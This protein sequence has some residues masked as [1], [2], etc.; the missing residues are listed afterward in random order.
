MEFFVVDLANPSGATESATAGRTEVHITSE[1][2][3][4][5]ASMDD[6]TVDEGAGT[7]K[8]TLRLNHPSSKQIR[9]TMSSDDV[10]GTATVSEDYVDFLGVF[11]I[12]AFIV[13]P[14]ELTKDFDIDIIDDGAAESDE[15]ITIKWTRDS[16]G[17][18]TPD[19]LNFTGTI[20]DNDGGTDP[21]LWSTTMTVGNPTGN[22]RGYNTNGD[23]HGSL[24]SLDVSE[25]AVGGVE[26]VVNSVTVD[27]NHFT[28]AY[29]AVSPALSN[30]GDYILEVAG[31]E[32]PLDSSGDYGSGA[33]FWGQTWLAA[34]APA[35]AADTFQ[36]TLPLDGRVQVCLRT[37]MERCPEITTTNTVATGKPTIT[38]TPQVGEV[39]TAT[40]GSIAD[41][42]DLPATFP[43]DYDFQWVSVDNSNNERLVGANSSTY[44]PDSS[45]V[46]KTIKVKVSFTDLRGL[47][48]GSADQRRRG[49]GGCGRTAGLCTGG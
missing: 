22:S 30:S 20:T 15:T 35:L 10:G 41:T 24:G 32:L 21:F 42:D 45:D 39:L 1:D 47:F 43:D 38:G 26:Y 7:M 27:S 6:V 16:P 33:R 31:V 34:N 23:G 29:F 3:V 49:P 2:S 37:A 12:R 8:L 48:G 5:V 4:P 9:Y 13:L 46:D 28:G 17:Q 11:N 18:V 19:V 36:T 14:G 25:F 44:S 40:L